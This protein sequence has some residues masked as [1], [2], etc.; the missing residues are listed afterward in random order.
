MS[1]LDLR[2]E[3]K[4]KKNTG[5]NKKE[6][7]DVLKN[8]ANENRNVTLTKVAGFLNSKDIKDN[9]MLLFLD[10][11]NQKSD[12][13][14][15][16]DEIKTIVRSIS[17]C[18]NKRELEDDELRKHFRTYEYCV[19]K[20]HDDLEKYGTIKT[21]WE[22][23]D[24]VLQFWF[25]TDVLVIAARS[26]V[27][28]TTIGLTLGNNIARL[29]PGNNTLFVSLEMGAGSLG[30]RLTNMELSRYDDEAH[31]PDS[32]LSIFRNKPQ[33]LQEIIDRKPYENL[34]ILDKSVMDLKT[35]ER[36]IKI[37]DCKNIIIDYMGYLQGEGKD[38]YSKI[39][40]IAKDLK[41]LAKSTETRI[42]ILTQTSRAG[43]DGKVPISMDMLRDSGAIEE[44]ADYI[45]GFFKGE[46][47]RIHAEYLK[48]RSALT[49]TK[50]DLL[51]KGLHLVEEEYSYIEKKSD[52]SIF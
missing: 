41:N 17:Q 23:A 18:K 28:K 49:G 20:F 16:I 40:K 12:R 27:G 5:I 15:E 45:L 51:N 48:T 2:K 22:R 32:C 14:L 4:G 11:V 39:T 42:G 1:L 35:L 38:N 26:G 50:F 52:Q 13:P 29:N 43:K 37:S 3:Y 46:E 47:N 31:T 44:S 33:K 6:L 25:P 8:G 19:W 36:Y 10:A 24:S 34:K 21:G 9:M 7:I 30:F